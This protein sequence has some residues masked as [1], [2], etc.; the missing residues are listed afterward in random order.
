MARGG[1]VSSLKAAARLA[2]FDGTAFQDFGSTNAHAIHSFF[3]AVFVA[4]MFFVWL[5]M[6]GTGMPDGTPLP[7]VAGYELLVY[8]GGWM[9]FP[10]IMWHVTGALD[11]RDRYAHFVT[12]Y[13][14]VAVIQNLLFFGLD[15]GLAAIG[16]SD[17]ARSFFGLVLLVY[18]LIYAWFTIRGALDLT[19]GTAVTIVVLDFMTALVWEQFS[20]GLVS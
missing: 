19:A 14:W 4:P 20:S 11:R 5:G 2:R 6:H 9:L 12:V 17:G 10:V 18:I 15:L 8:A 1:G 16:A 13:N 7:F 3:A